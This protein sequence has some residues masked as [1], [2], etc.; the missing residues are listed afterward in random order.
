[1]KYL[2]YI[3]C[4]A[5]CLLT[6]FS[7]K[8][9]EEEEETK[10]S[11]IGT[12]AIP[13]PSYVTAGEVIDV[14]FTGVTH[15]EG[16]GL[17]YIFRN[18]VT[19]VMDTVRHDYDPPEITGAFQYVIPDS[20]ASYT[21]SMGVYAEGYY[22]KFSYGGFTVI[23]PGLHGGTLTRHGIAP[24]DSKIQTA[25][26]KD[27]YYTRI[28][29]LNWFR[30]NLGM[31]EKGVPFNNNSPALDGIFGRYY[32]W[33]EA[34]TACPEGWRLPTES[35]WADLGKA[36]GCADAA[37]MQ[38][39]VGVAGS[40]MA[41]AY[42]AGTKMWVFWQAV[43]ITDASHFCAIPTGYALWNGSGYNFKDFEA[44]AVY[45]TADE[46]NGDALYRSIYQ[47]RNN[48]FIGAADKQT[49]A[50]SVRCVQDAL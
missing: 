29:S 41:D 21:I 4:A 38:D 26:G 5:L 12:L 23:K 45:W 2:K 50:A 31:K 24:E 6:L 36:L 8:K 33:E 37:P 7:C 40:L 18:P 34:R 25:D 44:R 14:T 49:F 9:K 32:T 3:V 20:L 11:L 19:E 39:F 13:F 16:K 47:N 35:D 15:P 27:Y 10:L 22:S 1:M 48:L 42:F 46:F 28:G 43:P 30:Q 17:G